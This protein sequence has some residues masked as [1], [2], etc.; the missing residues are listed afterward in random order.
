MF[1]YAQVFAT[2]GSGYSL[3]FRAFGKGVM[4]NGYDSPPVKGK[5]N[6]PASSEPSTLSAVVDVPLDFRL[7]RHLHILFARK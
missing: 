4:S 1:E 3:K 2:T 7:T 6:D 5:A